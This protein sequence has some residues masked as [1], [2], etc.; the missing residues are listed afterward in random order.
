MKCSQCGNEVPVQSKFCLN[1]GTPVSFDEN[2]TSAV[3][4][5]ARPER[6]VPPT[7]KNR[8]VI[9]AVIAGVALVALLGV[10]FAFMG[11]EKVVQSPPPVNLRQAPVVSAPQVPNMS[12][13]G[14]LNTEAPKTPNTPQA[15]PEVL[16]YLEYLKRVDQKRLQMQDEDKAACIAAYTAAPSDELKNAMRMVDDAFGDANETAKEKDTTRESEA[17][18][19]IKQLPQQW[20]QLLSEFQRVTPP[21][22]CRNLAWKYSDAL[23]STVAAETNLLIILSSVSDSSSQGDTQKAM[24]SLQGMVGKSTHIDDKFDTADTELGSICKYYGLQKPFTISS[25]R[26]SSNILQAPGR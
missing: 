17:T 16:A 4:P 2:V 24:Q 12:R 21:E 23:G 15:P 26:G 18:K 11:R 1:C 19:L 13:P 22:A 10:A 8:L 14:V 25:D 7:R 6:E 9:W 5:L 3:R 20:S